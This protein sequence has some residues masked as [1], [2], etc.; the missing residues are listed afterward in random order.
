MKNTRNVVIFIVIL[1]I[2]GG[3]YYFG[4]K[5]NIENMRKES[6]ILN[7]NKN[8]IIKL[9]IENDKGNVVFEKKD[10]GLWY[11][12]SPEKVL[13]DNKTIKDIL[14]VFSNMC[15]KESI[16][17]DIDP[18]KVEL[19]KGFINLKF[20]L[21]NGE[22]ETIH[23]GDT[24]PSGDCNYARKENS[25]EILLICSSLTNFVS[26]APIEYEN[27][28][29]WAENQEIVKDKIIRVVISNG[30]TSLTMEKD[31]KNEWS[32]V[33]GRNIDPYKRREFVKD[34]QTSE[35]SIFIRAHKKHM[36]RCGIGNPKYEIY[37]YCKDIKDPLELK[38]G[39]LS[40]IGSIVWVKTSNSTDIAGINRD[41][42][43]DIENL[44]K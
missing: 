39:N 8:D 11:M 31:S 44:Y 20:Y 34:L 4:Y 33:G 32:S 38:V 22:V 28:A 25:K 9:S 41:F 21:K 14:N 10:S 35:A 42:L 5:K 15:K 43:T 37:V 18:R 24:T 7:F 13:A 23:I 40:K 3:Y 2:L 29:L 12:I 36:Q 19:D 6:H 16:G 1:V 26:R 27:K 30:S 17:S